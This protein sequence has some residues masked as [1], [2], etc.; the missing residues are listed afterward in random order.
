MNDKKEKI[1]LCKIQY[2]DQCQVKFRFDDKGNILPGESIEDSPFQPWMTMD[3]CVRQRHFL[4]WNFHKDRLNYPL[5]RVGNRG[6]NKW[7]QIEWDQALDEIA[8]KLKEIKEKHGPE[9]LALITGF[10][11]HQWDIARFANIYGT[12]NV[13]S[14]NAR[15][16]GALEVWMNVLTYGAPAHYGPP[17]PEHCN[18]LVLWANRPA[19]MYPIKWAK[20]LKVRKRIVID[21]RLVSECKDADMWLQIRPGTDTALCMGWMNVIINEGL[22]DKQFVK[23]WTYGFDKLKERVQEYTP[24]KV[25]AITWIPEEQIVESARLYAKSSPGAHIQWGSP[26][27]YYGLN[28]DQTERARCCL[29]AITG[30]VGTL[31]GNYFNESYSKQV[32]LHDMELEDELPEEQV[33]KAI[34]SDKFK[35]MTWPG[36]YMIPEE[37][38]H[39]NRAFINR[40]SP[41]VAMINAIRTGKPYPV[42][43]LIVTAGNIMATVSETRH[44]YE[45]LKKVPF[46]A[47]IDLVMT[48]TAM[49]ADYV[50]PATSWLECPQIG[51]LEHKNCLYAGERVLPK[52]IP[53]KYDRRDDYDIWRSLGM[54]LG[55]KEHWP[56]ETLE[57]VLDYRLEP[58]GMTFQEFVTK[59]GFDVEPHEEKPYEKEGRFWTPTGKVE[60][61]S[62]ILEKLGYDPL[63][64][65][66]E[67]YESPVRT[68]ELAKK[69]PYITFGLKSTF[70]RHSS[71][72]NNPSLRKRHPEPIIQIHPETAKKHGIADGDWVWIENDRG[73]IKQKC[74]IFDKIHPQV[75]CCDFGWW[76]PEKP[77]EEPSL[78]G[79]WESN[80]N[81]LSCDDLE[82]CG[83]T[84]GNWYLNVFQTMIS[85][86]EG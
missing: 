61:Y 37:A 76:F 23:K 73:R 18:L 55:Q 4:E 84:S 75:I 20:G 51:F 3:G 67:P 41:L 80:I 11:N 26:T 79:I 86:A 43:G 12:P 82:A 83:R 65:Y 59:K 27:G 46:F 13:D 2:H 48:P 44:V 29:R 47:C 64:F 6:E 21:S 74:Q 8:Q 62:T 40:G 38:K 30:N 10:Y 32:K 71:H 60:L 22:Y 53:G 57:E 36:Y 9:H 58:F 50:L 34:G 72:R 70:Y 78:Y 33:K 35:A 7:Q 39:F 85:K 52:S 66:E 81:V 17:Y 14:V 63:P 1:A 28:S 77:A 16:C 54:R 68:P 45:A 31:G 15:I 19:D 5:K 25:S 49:L 24:K 56:W 42:H 69:Y